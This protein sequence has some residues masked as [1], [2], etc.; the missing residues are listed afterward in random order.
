LDDR[1]LRRRGTPRL[2]DNDGVSDRSRTFGQA[3]WSALQSLVREI[4][5]S[6]PGAHLI[7]GR[8][9]EIDLRLP[10]VLEGHGA[11]PA[12]FAAELTAAIARQIDEA[13]EEAGAFQPGNAFC[14]RCEAAACEHSRPPSA[15]HVFLGYGPTGAPRWMEFGQYALE[16]RHPEFDRLWEANPA[17]ITVLMDRVDLHGALLTSFRND[18]RVIL[19]QVVAGFFTLPSRPGEGREVLALSLQAV[20]SR[21]SGGRRRLGLNILGTAPGGGDLGMLWDRQGDLPWRRAVRWAQAALVSVA[22][23]AREGRSTRPGRR[24]SRPDAAGAADREPVRWWAA[25]ETLERRVMGVLQGL[26][27]RLE[28]DVRG[29]GRRTAHAGERHEGGERPTRKAID[30][31][32]AAGPEA[33]LRDER[34]GTVVVL[35]D[36]G[37]THFLTPAGRLVSSVR[38][39]RDAIEKKRSLG[40]WRPLAPTE[41]EA[42]RQAALRAG[43]G[44]VGG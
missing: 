21:T 28:Q 17:F 4:L 37:R 6:R 44:A 10:L 23:Q 22:R 26:A 11:D 18:D 13:I 35:G 25:D 39:S 8:L 34:A 27:R 31:I 19:G 40:L 36:R 3:A 14:H 38:Y 41:A 42:A 2:G 15:R 29:R 24:D 30:D 5:R 12:T 9:G 43:T 33:F 1:L 16:A 32:R 20:A 7:E